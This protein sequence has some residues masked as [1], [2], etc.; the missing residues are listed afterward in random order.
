MTMAVKREAGSRA[1]FDLRES[2]EFSIAWKC[3][4]RCGLVKEASLH[5]T[6]SFE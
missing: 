6:T 3:D 4:S 5:D 1:F 2:L